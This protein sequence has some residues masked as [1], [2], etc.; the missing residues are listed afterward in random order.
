VPAVSVVS[1]VSVSVAPAP[2]LAEAVSVSVA[3]APAPPLAEAD[4]LGDVDARV[5][6][7]LA[8]ADVLGD[9]DAL[10]AVLGDALVV[11]EADGLADVPVPV[12][13]DAPAEPDGVLAV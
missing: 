13:D 11:L 9:A 10:A 12:P 1:A 3:P 5:D 8:E 2:P 6:G 7:L 4:A